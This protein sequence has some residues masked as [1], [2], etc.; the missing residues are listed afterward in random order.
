MI[1]QAN[2]QFIISIA[3]LLGILFAIFRF[4][5]DPDAK[6]SE[7][8]KLINQRCGILHG[9]LDT[10]ISLIKNN[11]LKHIE[12][13]VKKL[14]ETQIRILTILEERQKPR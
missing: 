1:T 12:D 14:S 7:D 4:F 3:T 11:H 6:A 5:R 8:I 13:E 9:K 2:I 10:D